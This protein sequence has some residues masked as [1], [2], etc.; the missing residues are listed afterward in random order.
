MVIHGL[1]GMNKILTLKQSVVKGFI[2]LKV[3]FSIF[4]RIRL[5]LKLI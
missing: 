5:Q 3:G 1:L 4:L 2:D